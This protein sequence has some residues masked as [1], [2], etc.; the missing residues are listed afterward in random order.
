MSNRTVLLVTLLVISCKM[1][2]GQYSHPL[3]PP[4]R[5]SSHE[6]YSPGV[7][8]ARFAKGDSTLSVSTLDVNEEVKV[9][10]VLKEPP[11]SVHFDARRNANLSTISSARA[12]IDYQHAQLLS[13]VNRL[14][15]GVQTKKSTIL[16]STSSQVRFEYKTAINGFAITTRRWV[17]E[18]IKKLEYVRGIYEDKQ[19]HMNDEV[20]NHIILADSVWAK[21]GVT[22]KGVI[23]GLLDTGIDYLHPDLGGGIGPGFKVLGGYNFV[24]N[25]N[26]ILDDNGHGTYVGGIIAANGSTL[27]GVSPDAKLMV[28]KVLD[29]SGSGL[30]S[31]VIAG[32]ER[33]L[34]PDGNPNTNDA[35]NIIHMSLG[36]PGDPDDIESEAVDNATSQGVL[37]V[38]SSGNGGPTYGYIASPGCARTALTVGATDDADNIASFSSRGPSQKIYGIKPEIVAPG[39]LITSCKM[40]GGYEVGDGTSA[41]APHVSGAAAL[42]LQLHPTWSP[43]MLKSALVQGARSIGQDVWTQGNGRLDVYRSASISSV[44]IPSTLDLGLDDISQPL[45]DHQDTLLLFNPTTQSH[46]FDL[47][48]VGPIPSGV[49]IIVSPSKLL[50]AS[51]ASSSVIV[52]TTVDNNLVPIPLVDPR[53]YYGFIQ[54]VTDIDT[55]TVPVAFVKTPVLRLIF[56]EAPWQVIV[57]NGINLEFNVGYPGNY[58]EFHLP[59]GAYDVITRYM[60][61]QTLVFRENVPVNT[62]TTLNINKSEANHLVHIRTVDEHGSPLT[63]LYFGSWC[64]S[65]KNSPFSLSPYGEFET[66]MHF[67]NVS[68]A[69]LWEWQCS[70]MNGPKKYYG[71]NGYLAGCTGDTTQL[72]DPSGFQHIVY[73]YHVDPSIPS[74]CPIHYIGGIANGD[75]SA[76]PMTEPFTEDAFYPLLPVPDFGTHAGG[77]FVRDNYNV[78]YDSRGFGSFDDYRG[79]GLQNQKL[80]FATPSLIAYNRDTTLVCGWQDPRPITVLTKDTLRPGLY[81]PHWSGQLVNNPSAI[82]VQSYR[83]I[84]YDVRAWQSLFR[85]Q[86][87]D[88][89]PSPGLDFTL[90]KGATKVDSGY[91]YQRLDLSGELRFVASSGLYKL[92]LVD[93]SYCVSNRP[94]VSTV[95]LEFNT[96]ASDPNPPTIST[97]EILANGTNADVFMPHIPI[98]VRFA[99]A[100]E[101]PLSSAHLYVK[102]DT[103]ASWSEIAVTINN[104]V[105]TGILPINLQVGF[106]SIRIVAQDA[107]GNRIT[108]E[109]NPAFLIGTAAPRVPAPMSPA[110]GAVGVSIP[111][112]LVWNRVAEASSF[113]L[114]IAEDSSFSSTVFDD[115]TVIDT[116][117]QVKDLTINK[118]YYWRV[119]SNNSGGISPFSSV[120]C[121]TASSYTNVNEI[122]GTV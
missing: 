17:V 18:V 70:A 71:F 102:Q 51:G 114:E 83:G 30:S 87:N 121:F 76:V 120:W 10:V 24:Q 110:N 45:W 61:Q 115:S 107:T 9:I 58:Q 54:A 91:V 28:F 22:G 21:F 26:D 20:S 7:T 6:R 39:V 34:D 100:D 23:V 104:G 56:D 53:G 55:F 94:G 31:W 113:R 13:D 5:F 78:V 101:S 52:N 116:M 35:V 98:R 48:A 117:R 95:T 11:L 15:A 16:K 47:S 72:N 38:A 4:K 69:Y 109:S 86:A 19:V 68:P 82:V 1:L 118:K 77:W 42:L 74:I 89:N 92:Q 49:K 84:L 79:F 3:P 12:S 65:L 73:E 103:G 106:C 46:S 112:A 122:E 32:I 80:L 85:N 41:S 99:V 50:L 90:F 27:K 59:I 63:P 75:Y 97:L 88:F 37:C 62:L 36:G 43:S 67:S 96:G 57:H 2:L 111:I 29:A 40:G 64:L 44:V 119:N 81:P 93:S 105:Y 60:D 14:S 108:A 25:N 66:E 33:A 8:V